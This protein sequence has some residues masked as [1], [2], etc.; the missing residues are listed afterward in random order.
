[1]NGPSKSPALIGEGSARKAE[2]G[3][4]SAPL[5][6]LVRALARQAAREAFI[7]ARTLSSIQPEDA[8]RDRR[9]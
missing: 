7:G 8:P 3:A 9:G 4:S 1:M 6:A 5:I 2:E